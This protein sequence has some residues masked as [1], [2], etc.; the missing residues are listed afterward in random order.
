MVPPDAEHP[1]DLG[2]AEVVQLEVQDLPLSRVDPSGSVTDKRDEFGLLGRCANVHCLAHLWDMLCGDLPLAPET[3]AALV[4]GHRIQPWAEPRLV[5]QLPDA[6]YG[7]KER[8]MHR[9]GCVSRLPE[10][11]A[12]VGVQAGRVFVIRLGQGGRVA[13]RDSR[14]E[15][16]T[17]A[18]IIGFQ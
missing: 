7:D 15:I 10:E 18:E 9:V 3:A 2:G 1:G 5:P 4:T 6:L 13:T 17:H 11:G 14:N 12:A 16:V 8:V